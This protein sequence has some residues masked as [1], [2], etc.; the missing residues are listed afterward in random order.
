MKS[1]YV[2][3]GIVAS[4]ACFLILYIVISPHSAD[5]L[6]FH[7]PNYQLGVEQAYSQYEEP[8]D[9]PLTLTFSDDSSNLY[10]SRGNGVVEEWNTLNR[11]QTRAFM[12]NSIFSYVGS[13][14]SLI[15]KSVGDNVEIV[16]LGSNDVAPLARD[17]Y[18]HSA[19]DRT[20]SFLLLSTG[21]KSLEMWSL[22]KKQLSKRWESHKSVRNGV[23]IAS[24]GKY[25]AAAEGTYDSLANFHHTT[26]QLWEQDNALPRF[27]FNGEHAQEVHGV[28]SILFSP[29]SSVIA[30]DSQVNRQAG[31]TVWQASTGKLVF[32]VR[33]LDSYWVR[34]LAFSPGGKYLAA[35]DELGNLRIWNLDLQ[36]KV[37]QTQVRGQAIHSIAF[38]TDSQFLAAGIQDSTIQVW[39]LDTISDGLLDS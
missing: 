35:G 9:R 12:T 27:L 32:K 11:T 38:S 26:I 20:G 28:W 25:V 13:R 10:T 17:F 8:P 6:P 34:A 24:E 16:E 22:D 33:G 18:I 7:T 1:S 29:D 36:K 21:G 15:T 2:L 19:V 5:S 31:V 30:V 3:T 37:W 23:A 39:N 14:H 4:L